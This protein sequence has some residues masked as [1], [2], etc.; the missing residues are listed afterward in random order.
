MP[1]TVCHIGDKVTVL[2][3]TGRFLR[4]QLFEQLTDSFHHLNIFALVMAADIVGFTDIC[5]CHHGI[6][7][8][9]MVIDKQPVADLLTF[10]VNRQWFAGNRIENH[11]R[12]QFFREVVR[13]VVI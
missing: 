5:L 13:P 10:T 4:M 12:D 7:G 9:G 6:Q 8:A 1:R 11:Q 3:D 2:R